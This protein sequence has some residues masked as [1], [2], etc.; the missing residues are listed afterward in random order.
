[1]GRP[2][3]KVLVVD[4][5]AL[6]R[7]HLRELLTE[8][9][10]FE[11]TTAR[12]G[13]D[14]LELLHKID[15]D[16]ITLDINMPEMDGLTCLSR[17]MTEKPKPVVMVSSLTE[18]GAEVTYQ[19][20]ALG[21]VDYIPKPDGTISLSLRNS[22][23]Q[24]IEKVR[25]ASLARVKNVRGLSERLRS[26]N[27]RSANSVKAKAGGPIT[28]AQIREM[29]VV[30]IGVS[31]G[32][33]RVLE[34][35]LPQ[36]PAD[37]PWPILIAQHMPRNFTGTFAKR[38]DSICQLGVEE[39]A[40][41]SPLRPGRCYVGRGDAD[42]VLLKRGSDWIAAT[43]PCD[44]S[45][46]W[47]PSVARMVETALANIT[48]ERL[49]GVMLTGMG[50]D[51]AEAMS[52]LH[53]NGGRTVAEAESTAVVYG[54]PGE[55]VKRGGA[56]AILPSHQIAKKLIEWLPAAATGRSLSRRVS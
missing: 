34:E 48:P 36:L 16:V 10:E 29:G 35:I 52:E 33:P 28:D 13:R 41:R 31:T 21:A 46:I 55:L 17:I 14:A 51:G 23:A 45:R 18:K 40:D 1:M 12:D 3:I 38:L 25:A 4:D 2:K 7:K 11:V 50:D 24:I 44:A 47:H 20:L 39:V 56:D 6:M 8:T 49:V 54:M 42:L 15:P 32:G 27:V 26:E 19:A 30:L 37:F 5:S 22:S 53:R 9:G 43:V